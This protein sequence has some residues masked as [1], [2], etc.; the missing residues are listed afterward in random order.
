[1][2]CILEN[3]KMAKVTYILGWKEYKRVLIFVALNHKG[4]K[5]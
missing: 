4:Q 1:M 5:G 3:L 2:A